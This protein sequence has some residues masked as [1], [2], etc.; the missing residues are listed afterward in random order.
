MSKSETNLAWLWNRKVDS[1]AEAKYSKK[2]MVKDDIGGT[3]ELNSVV[4]CKLE[5]Y[6]F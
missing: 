4:S 6:L 3:K 5:F 1:V 2:K